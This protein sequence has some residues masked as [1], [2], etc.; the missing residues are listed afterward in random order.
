[1]SSYVDI[2][3]DYPLRCAKLW[4]DFN[5]SAEAKNLE[6]TF[7]LMCAA[8]GFA[9]PYE[10]LRIQPGQAQERQGHP[11]FNNFDQ[12]KYEHSLKKVHSALNVAM[13]ECLLFN[14]LHFDRCYYG[15]AKAI[16][17]V[18]DMAECRQSGSPPLSGQSARKI[19]K[20]L[21]NAIAHS[22]IFAFAGGRSEDITD[23][24]FFSEVVDSKI[25]DKKVVIGYDVIVMPV[26]DFQAFLT[27]WFDLLRKVSPKGKHLKLIFSNALE[28]DD[29]PITSYG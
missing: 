14:G 12:K 9:T 23:L 20:A 1:M 29:E 4:E 28:T 24:G 10:H 7:M 21:R 15:H 6:V 13:A 3:N 2:Y 18:R 16:N 11:A 26:Q 5:A 8:G 19:V 17:E 22:N 25:R 27:S